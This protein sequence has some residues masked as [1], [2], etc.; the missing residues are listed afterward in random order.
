MELPGLAEQ[1][2]QIALNL[3]KHGAEYVILKVRAE[4]NRALYESLLKRANET[5][6]MSYWYGAR[7]LQYTFSVRARCRGSRPIC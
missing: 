6:K 4:S 7:S 1:Q 5:Y 2:Q 3:K